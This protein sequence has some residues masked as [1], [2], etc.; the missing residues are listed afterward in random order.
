MIEPKFE[1]AVGMSRKWDAREAGKEVAETAIKKLS[2]PPDFFLLFSTIHYEK[3]GGFQEF[4]NGVWDVLPKGT[5][6]IGGTVVGFMNN[7]G[8]YTRGASALAI[9]Y[10][11]MDVSIG[12]G[13]NTKR[14]PEKAAK[15][16]TKMIKNGLITSKYPNKFLLS[17][18]SSG[19][20]PSIPIIGRK[21]VITSKYGDVLLK[22]LNAT[23]RSLQIGPGREDEI[24]ETLADEL[25]EYDIV[26]GSTLDDNKW[27]KNY[28]F[29][30]N[31]VFTNSVV[32]L[33]FKTDL[34][35]KIN[36]THGLK[37]TGVK[38]IPTKTTLYN[39]AIQRIEDKPA[40]E[41]FLKIVKWPED[42]FDE[43][44]HRRTLFYPLCYKKEDFLCPRVIALIIKN[45]IIFT[46]KISKD[47]DLEIYSASGTGLINSVKENLDEYER[48]NL[49]FGLVVSCC[50]R[51]EALGKATFK[52][53]EILDKFYGEIPFLVFFASGEDVYKSGSSPVRLNESFNVINFYN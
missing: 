10:S 6:L 21:R 53:H 9:S 8:C 23:C 32:A 47:D 11:N 41:Q 50:A 27:E 46:N 26:G 28:Q 42:L 38:I 7:Y 16:C 39:C 13:H 44:I 14:S 25:K 40:A 3:H 20:V 43:S 24:I 29:F 1:A 37:P 33:G 5:P 4:L 52:E 35:W 36:S 15:R 18:I 31:K 2:R 30:D 22:T 45:T 19:I 17:I 12:I 51:L 48:N 49:K 34:S